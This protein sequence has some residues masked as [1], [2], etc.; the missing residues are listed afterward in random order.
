MVIVNMKLL[1]ILLGFR[2]KYE[3]SLHKHNINDKYF[4]LGITICKILILQCFLGSKNIV[5]FLELK[6]KKQ[7]SK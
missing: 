2:E 1:K 3:Q 6:G 7:G 5:K 4:V